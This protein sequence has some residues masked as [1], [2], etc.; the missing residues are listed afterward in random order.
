VEDVEDTEAQRNITR[1]ADTQKSTV[2]RITDAAA[3]A[4]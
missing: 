2:E 3:V 1:A 4:H